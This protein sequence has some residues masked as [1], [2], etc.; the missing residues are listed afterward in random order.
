[1]K[2]RKVKSLNLD[3]INKRCDEVG[4]CWLWAHGCTNGHPVARHDGKYWLLRRLIWGWRNGDIPDGK[5]I[6]TTCEQK[7]CLQPEHLELVTMQTL[8]KR[9]GAKGGIMSSP[10]RSAKIAKTK[11]AKYGRWTPEQIN[12]IRNSPETGRAMAEKYKTSPAKISQIR[13]HKILKE[14]SNPFSGLGARL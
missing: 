10:T 7:L 3:I 9:L 13:L 12:D 11:R 5:I 6:T 1:M 14:F 4:D 8:T 2:K